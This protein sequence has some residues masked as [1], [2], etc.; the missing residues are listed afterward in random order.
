MQSYELLDFG[1][2][3]R[4]EQWAK[5]R[6]VRPDPTA[7]GQPRHPEMWSEA[8]AVYKGEKGIGN[9]E[10]GVGNRESGVGMPDK[11]NVAFDDIELIVRLTPYKHTG[12]FPEQ[13]QNW[14]WAREKGSERSLNIL[15]L[16]AYTGGAT[17]ALAKDGHMVTH[18]DASKPTVEWAKENAALNQIPSDRIRWITD[19]APTFVSREIKREKTYDAII[20]DPPAYG[21]GPSGKTWR[22]Q[23]D[24]APLLESCV[25]LLSDAPCFLILNGYAQND[26][27]QSFHRLLSGIFHTKRPEL[28]PKIESEELLLQSQDGRTLSTGI[29][30]RCAF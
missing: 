30:A 14:R 4:L 17:V 15:S 9:W 28:K 18:V 12:V 1:N 24:L 19:D 21:H 25:S 7:K 23:R 16:F 11:W 20:I 3:Q 2:E 5:Y 22:V 10:L 27:P 29:V 26:T 13:L 6:L 8:D